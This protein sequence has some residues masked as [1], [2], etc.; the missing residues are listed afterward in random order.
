MN[1]CCEAEFEEY[2]G[3]FEKEPNGA[4]VGCRCYQCRVLRGETERIEP[5]KERKRKKVKMI[6]IKLCKDE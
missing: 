5:K 6:T 1:I 3:Q 2:K 4:Y